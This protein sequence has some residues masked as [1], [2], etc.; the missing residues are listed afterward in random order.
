MDA[1][2]FDLDGGYSMG[3]SEEHTRWAKSDIGHMHN[4]KEEE[5]DSGDFY[6]AF[7]ANWEGKK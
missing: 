2:G 5:E 7:L 6:R 4:Q 3:K 1:L